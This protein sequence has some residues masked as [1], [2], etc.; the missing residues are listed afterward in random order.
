MGIS[1][2]VP[3]YKLSKFYIPLTVFSLLVLLGYY[4]IKF[5]KNYEKI[6]NVDYFNLIVFSI[7][8]FTFA[9][10]IIVL[11]HISKI[12]NKTI[13][14][15]SFFALTLSALLSY[16]LIPSP[17]CPDCVGNIKIGKSFHK[18]GFVSSLKSYHKV[19]L[20]RI[21][22][23][24]KSYERFLQYGDKLGLDYK[25]LFV[26]IGKET[27]ETKK[28]IPTRIGQHPPLWFIIIYFW[29]SFFGESY[30][31]HI[32]LAN[33]IAIGYLISLFFFLGL[34]SKEE[35]YKSKLWVLAIVLF[36]PN[37][38]IQSTRVTNDL[39]LGIFVTWT[40]FF[41]LKNTKDTIN[42]NDF[43]VGLVYSIT[44]LTKF[45]SLTVLLPIT[46]YYLFN[47]RLKAIPKLFVFLLSF[48][49][50]PLTLYA[51]FGYDMVLN[52]IIGKT[53]HSVFVDNRGVSLPYYVIETIF[54]GQ[55]FIGIPFVI[56]LFTHISKIRQYLTQ[57]KLV[58][59]YLFFAFFY[60][61]HIIMPK[62]D[63][64]RHLSGYLSF[65]VPLLAHIYSNCAEKNKMFLSIGIFLLVNNL[66]IIINL[67][68][69]TIYFS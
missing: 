47:F 66:L 63:L 60:M 26:N 62:S 48:S 24:P 41:L 46:L 17:S 23:D 40:L 54:Y 1:H 57:D 27:S 58:S 8:F 13:L 32:I 67:G 44:V 10:F 55:Y 16:D 22:K 50:L 68:V 3:K 25:N 20:F 12:Q 51:V 39:I 49:L 37:F 45:T 33:F 30:F 4:C 56:L 15:I 9:T 36:L 21:K 65:N 42:H 6:Y 2:E 14:I 7:I 61:M 59:A 29:Q 31:S 5:F 53:L 28:I 35:E 34:F 11:L 43:I 69:L 64:A 18:I 19:P 52:I 38:L